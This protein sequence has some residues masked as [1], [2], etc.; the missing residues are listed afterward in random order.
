MRSLAR[1]SSLLAILS[2]LTV[3]CMTKKTLPDK[4]EQYQRGKIMSQMPVA[5]PKPEKSL[6][7]PP[8]LEQFFMMYH[9]L[10]KKEM[11]ISYAE[12]PLPYDPSEQ[13]SKK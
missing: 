1:T 11:I 2:A 8:P 10:G 4:Q 6:P 7:A 5:P 12:N 13:Y 3:A 9:N